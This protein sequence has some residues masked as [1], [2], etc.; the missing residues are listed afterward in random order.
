MIGHLPFRRA[1][2]ASSSR[3]SA[4]FLVESMLL[5]AFLAISMAVFVQ[6]FGLSV[7]RA[8][9]GEDL[10]R[11]VAVASSSAERFAADPSGAEGE[12]LV[13]GMRVVC[14]VQEEPS[15]QGTIYHATIRVYDT[16]SANGSVEPVYTLST[17]RYVGGVVR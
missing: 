3:E 16:E 4:A 10:S 8:Y 17:A 14:D 6:V 15:A 7:E 5:L 11:A 2:N 1:S 12:S 13:D 9:K